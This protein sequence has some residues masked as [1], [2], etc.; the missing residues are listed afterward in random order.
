MT[1]TRCSSSDDDDEA[2]AKTG[3]EAEAEAADGKELELARRPMRAWPEDGRKRRSRAAENEFTRARPKTTT[4]HHA[5]TQAQQ[6]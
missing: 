5:R 4:N 1:R 6:Q 3:E 2:N